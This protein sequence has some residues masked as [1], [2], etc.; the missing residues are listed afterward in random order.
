MI[1]NRYIS[2]KIQSNNSSPN[3]EDTSDLLGINPIKSYE[4]KIIKFPIL[5]NRKGKSINNNLSEM[6]KSY[7]DEKN[8][9]INLQKLRKKSLSSI[10]ERKKKINILFFND[11]EKKNDLSKLEN[12]NINKFNKSRSNLLE[13]IKNI[14]L[15][16]MIL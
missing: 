8:I 7:K 5:K 9:L 11:I 3:N 15:F 1:N 2:Y 16:S 6:L 13:K 4:I 12:N 10:R 14:S